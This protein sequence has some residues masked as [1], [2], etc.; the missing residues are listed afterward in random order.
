I[1]SAVADDASAIH[2][3]YC[4]RQLHPLVMCAPFV[5]RTYEKP[6]GYAGDYEMVNMILRDPLEGA[7]I[8]AK[9]VNSYFLAAPPAEAHRNRIDYLTEMLSDETRRRVRTGK[10]ARIFNLGCGPAR[11]VQS[12]L[13]NNDL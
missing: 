13:A 1:T 9:V 12:F 7:S 5:H 3:A 8:F 10:V 6:L 4:R 2:R 11:E